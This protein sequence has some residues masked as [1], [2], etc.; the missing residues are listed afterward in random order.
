[1]TTTGT[2]SSSLLQ[3][4]RDDEDDEED[5]YE[6]EEEEEQSASQVLHGN[7]DNEEDGDD[8]EEED[9]DDR[10]ATLFG[11][12]SLSS[13]SFRIH[14]DKKT[15]GRGSAETATEAEIYEEDDDD[16]DDEPSQEDNDYI[17]EDELDNDEDDPEDQED[18]IGQK[19]KEKLPRSSYPGGGG[20]GGWRRRSLPKQQKLSQHDDTSSS[21]KRPKTM[22]S[23][24][25]SS[26]S[27]PSFSKP[28]LYLAF[29]YLQGHAWHPTKSSLSGSARTLLQSLLK[30]EHFLPWDDDEENTTKSRTE[31]VLSA[32][33]DLVSQQQQQQTNQV[34][35][36]HSGLPDSGIVELTREPRRE[37][38]Q[39][40]SY[41][42]SFLSVLQDEMQNG[43]SGGVPA[44]VL[45]KR[46]CLTIAPSRVPAALDAEEMAMAALEFL[47][48][49]FQPSSSVVPSPPKLPLIRPVKEEN[50][51]KK[52]CYVPVGTWQL[53]DPIFVA[54]MNVL[55]DWFSTMLPRINGCV[56]ACFFHRLRGHS[57]TR[58]GIY[59]CVKANTSWYRQRQRKSSSS[60]SLPPPLLSVCFHPSIQ[61][62]TQQQ[63][64]LRVRNEEKDEGAEGS[65]QLPSA[66]FLVRQGY[67]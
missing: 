14:T 55:E 61:P 36:V 5:D 33:L 28:P 23:V 32:A 20:S 16:D 25:P 12:P 46:C 58:N 47:S 21:N 3:W 29:A 37:G 26:S 34:V 31:K 15:E 57:Q 8:E 42:Q 53:D 27:S 63:D 22:S 54:A 50:D 40:L 13:S 18:A 60:H 10:P 19:T 4:N 24:W 64:S 2:T 43:S 67:Q 35:V 48:S 9:E 44:R 52:R 65:L 66:S 39:R 17:E 1:M 30:D 7:L 62:P 6:E 56:E 51:I 59:C 11:R 45:L 49:T 38:R 41:L